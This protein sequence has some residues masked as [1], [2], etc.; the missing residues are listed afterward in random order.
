LVSYIEEGRLRVFENRVLRIY[1]DS[2]DE[3]RGE[4]RR[5]HNGELYVLYGSTNITGVIKSRIIRWEKR[6][7]RMEDRRE[8]YRVLVGRPDGMRPP[9]YSWE[10]N[11]KMN[12]QLMRW[13]MDWI[14]IAQDMDRWHDVVDAEISLRFS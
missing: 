12:L 10:D 13:G 11:I 2:K 6:F 14:V 4:W 3:V 5:L 7:P 1:E 9:R 8:A